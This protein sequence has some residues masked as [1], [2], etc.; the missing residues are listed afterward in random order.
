[1]KFGEHWIRLTDHD[2]PKIIYFRFM[3]QTTSKWHEA[4]KRPYFMIF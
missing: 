1:M 3:A 2:A 4:Y